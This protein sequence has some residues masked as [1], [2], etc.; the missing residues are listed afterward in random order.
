VL[1]PFGYTSAAFISA[2]VLKKTFNLNQGFDYWDEEDIQMQK[3]MVVLV[4][5]RKG[6]V[7]TDAVLKW[8]GQNYNKRW[9]LWVHYY[10]PHREY[11]P[12]DPY[13]HLYYFDL[14]AGEIAFMDSQIKRLLQFLDEKN[15]S[16]KTI[17]VAIADHGESLGEHDEL[18]H[19]TFIYE[20]TQHIPFLI[21]VPGMKQKDIK[22]SHVVS[23][24]D[25]MPT[26][27][28]F[29]SIPAPP[30]LEGRSLKKLIQGQEKDNDEGQA[31]LQSEFPFLHFGWSKIF[32]LVS[33]KYKYIQV[34]K[35]ELY[36]L[37]KDEGE[38]QNI[39]SGNDKLVKELDYNLEKIKQSAHSKIAA[40]ASAGL[41][42]DEQTRKQ[43]EALGYAVGS[44]KADPERAKKKNPK[45]YADLVVLLG[46][47]HS[48]L[49]TGNY[50][51]LIEK[52][53]T[54]L[55]RDPENLFALRLKENALFGLGQYQQAIDWDHK[56]M[57]ILGENGEYYYLIATCYM[58]MGKLD[59]A[60]QA[61]EKSIQLDPGKSSAKYILA[62]IYLKNG[63]T[64]KALDLID[65]AEIRDT[66]M[67][68]L[69]MAAYYQTQPGRMGKA[70]AEFEL[71]LERAPKNSIVKSDYAQY[72]LAAGRPKKAL[73]LFEDAEKDDPSLKADMKLQDLIE[74][75]RK[76]AE[77][78]T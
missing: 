69:F 29:L 37:E 24:V 19:G 34:P 42:L 49:A 67:G 11:D 10:D 41:K 16:R 15:L 22:I 4:A 59:L 64:Q 20:G 18:T 2:A 43:I 47:M 60:Q 6:N 8:L 74:Q 14:Y 76:L 52:A 62:R 68:H 58:R 48:D 23:Q 33:G 21:K 78:G 46:S 54:V 55:K 13:K 45:D 9:F 27:L 63:Q 30:E 36:D 72:L 65:A 32:G 51:I 7:T 53:E 40:L 61:L 38:M 77:K 35:P 31:F 25:V 17:I 1:K 26:I 3:D 28:D 12:P 44:A 66:W 57:S 39:A 70:E 56:V 5:E 73:E 75:A 71:A 50:K